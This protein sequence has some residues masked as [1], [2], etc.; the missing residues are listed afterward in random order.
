VRA[1]DTLARL[2][3]GALE[4]ALNQAEYNVR[5]AQ[6][7]LTEAREGPSEAELAAAR[8][9]VRDAQVALQVAQHGYSATL[10]S[11]LDSAVR[12]RKIEFDWYVGY[13]QARKAEFEQG[14]LSQS[15]HDHAMNATISAEGRLNE[16]IEQAQMEE[17]QAQ[18]Q[19]DQSRSAFYQA[20]ERLRLLQSGPVTETLM[21]AELAADQ[22]LLAREQARTDL[23]AAVLRAPFDGVVVGVNAAPGDQVSAGMKLVTLLDPVAV[24]ARVTVIEEDLPLIEAGQAVE[25]FFDARP[26]AAVTGHVARIVPQREPASDRPLYPVYIVLDELPAGLAPGMT[27]DASIVIASRSDVLQ[28]PRAVVHARSDGTAQ[29]EVWANGQT[30][31]RM[32]RV[33]LRGDVYVEILDGLREGEQ[34]VAE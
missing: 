27:V 17:L 14:H 22:A 32:V 28:L 25:V 20:A 16:A 9:T 26:D 3:T 6:L 10:N 19:V 31:T 1:G 4:Q 15:D 8:A 24:E 21:R 18:N 12:A 29:V 23:E 2:E 13:Y 11:G 7:D 34:V 33:G 5:L 30:E